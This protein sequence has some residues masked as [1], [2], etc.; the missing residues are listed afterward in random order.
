LGNNHDRAAETTLWVDGKLVGTYHLDAYGL[1]T[2][3]TPE[4]FGGKFTFFSPDTPEG[5]LAGNG[6][7]IDPE[8]KGLIRTVSWAE[9]KKPQVTYRVSNSVSDSAEVYLGSKGLS[10]GFTG[11][12]G[13]SGQQFHHVAPIERDYSTETEIMIRLVVTQRPTQSNPG[14]I[15]PLHSTGRPP[16][17]RDINTQGGAYVAGTMNIS[18]DFVG[19]DS[20]R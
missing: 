6:E 12:S 1:A 2:I 17:A 8:D 19:R 18:G 9:V 13:Q 20:Y 5:Y 16:R 3:E 15:R 14:N 4:S 10:E 11:L 7:T